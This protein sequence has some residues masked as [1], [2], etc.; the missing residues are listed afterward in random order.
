MDSRSLH[1]VLV[2]KRFVF[3]AYWS[4]LSLLS[5]LG[6]GKRLACASVLFSPLHR[7][8]YNAGEICA[9]R[10]GLSRSLGSTHAKSAHFCKTGIIRAGSFSTMYFQNSVV[11]IPYHYYVLQPLERMCMTVIEDG[12]PLEA[13]LRIEMIVHMEFKLFASPSNF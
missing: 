13:Y 2:L 12:R 9:I 5:F 7:D 1:L 3:G 8:T 4:I 10:N 6:Y 11:S